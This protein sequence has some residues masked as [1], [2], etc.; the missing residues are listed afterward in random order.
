MLVDKS[1][2]EALFLNVGLASDGVN[3]LLEELRFL[4][5]DARTVT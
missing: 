4:H 1:D 5:E 2:R 3:P